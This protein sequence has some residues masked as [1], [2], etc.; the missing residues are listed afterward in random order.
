MT[1]DLPTAS[2]GAIDAIV[3]G[4]HGDP[5]SV[6]G[7]HEIGGDV[8][9]RA[10][11]PGASSVFILLAPNKMQ[12][13]M[14][15]VH[16]AGFFEGVV[17][18]ADLPVDYR[19]R[20]SWDHGDT[21]ELD[22]PYAF[23]QSLT[24]FDEYLLAE[25]TD[26]RMYEKL[27]AHISQ[28]RGRTGVHFAV[29]APNAER[30][31]V[32]GEFNNWDGRRHPMRFHHNSGI[33]DIFM[34]GL[35]EGTVYKYE[36]KSR[37]A[38][39]TVLKADP[40]AFYS[41]RRPNTASI[42]WDIN[43]HQWQDDSWMLQREERHRPD[44]PINVY[45]V[46]L[47]SWRRKENN[48]FLTYA[49]L[50]DELVAYAKEMGYTHLELMPVA[51]HPFDGSWGYQVTGYFAATSRYGTPDQLMAFIDT[52]HQAGLG[53]ILDWVPAHFPRDEHGLAYFDGTHLYEHADPR[54]GAHPDWGT[55][56]FNF[57]RSEVRQF[58]ISNAIF[59]LDKY[60]IDGLRVDA[61]ASMLYL[62]F[63][64]EEGQWIPNRYGGRE[65][66]EAIDFLRTFNS[67]LHSEYPGAITIAEESTAW[68]GVTQP[69]ESGGLGFDYKWNMG[70]MHDTLRYFTMDPIYRSFHHGTLTFSLLY[71]FSERFLLPFSHDE[72]VHLK[73]SMLDKMP[74][75]NWRKFANYR[76][77]LA[78]QIAHPGKKMLFMGGEFGH[79][80]EW[81]EAQSLDWH[82]LEQHE[83]HQQLRHFVGE[84]NDLY[85]E[86]SALYEEDY[87]WSGFTWLDLHD[88][89]RSILA[90]ARHA[91]QG[92]Q[93]ILVACNFTPVV[94]ESYRLGVPRRGAY[95]EILNS[96]AEKFGGSGVTN[97]DVVHSSEYGWHNQANSI[98]FRLP[99]LGVVYLK[100]MD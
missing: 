36:V 88:A 39:Y 58:L 74:G 47:G 99:P 6:L 65:N 51:E 87:D 27:G 93:T 50:A 67:R 1:R 17:S 60:H 5:F 26:L 62:D 42:V 68:G 18:D 3:G 96:D 79:W 21:I 13:A 82:L 7:P 11:L 2:S 81:S 34:P 35:G 46:H 9:V 24:D 55:L 56:I 75:D 57:G 19:F 64:R 98:E 61:V 78:Y 48:E 45:E 8:V 10:F 80:R 85:R 83:K 90:F 91:P 100:L 66:L 52:C 12:V 14:E 94:R 63:S 54:Q 84:L 44:Q 38:G 92:G 32:V 40:V 69:A 72:V 77:L 41:E 97:S 30:V 95:K 71:A 86:E 76:A 25:G 22:D 49:D 29:W 33:W 37:H 89:Q 20:I 53:V 31:S 23:S 28:I 43:K 16:P 70:W 4:Y 15:Q 73:K 59:W